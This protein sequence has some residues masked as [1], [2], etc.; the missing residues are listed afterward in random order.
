MRRLTIG[1]VLA[2]AMQPAWGQVSDAEWNQCKAANPAQ[3]ITLDASIDYCTHL[4]RNWELPTDRLAEAH[5]IRGSHYF[6][7]VLY[8]SAITDF[9]QA[10]EL[11]P[12]FALAYYMRGAT[13]SAETLYFLAVSDYTR[14]LAHKPDLGT[15]LAVYLARARTYEKM[16]NNGNA[17]SDYRAVLKL[18]P[19]KPEAIASLKRLG[20]APQ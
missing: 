14:A 9:S 18:A 1:L 2:I 3:H 8:V 20:A 19:G 15:T 4:M 7:K 12:D 13:Y 5:E 16:H 11:K 6:S 10:I 17:V